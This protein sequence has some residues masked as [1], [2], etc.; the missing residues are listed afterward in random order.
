MS[1]IKNY[2]LRDDR[3]DLSKMFDIETCVAF[4]TNRVAK[5]IEIFKKYW[6]K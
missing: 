2:S 5:E 3:E 1:I 6:I 4:V